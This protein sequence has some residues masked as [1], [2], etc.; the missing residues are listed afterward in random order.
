M[1]DDDDFDQDDD[2]ISASESVW[3]NEESGTMV[4]WQILLCVP[5]VMI[6]ATTAFIAFIAFIALHDRIQMKLNIA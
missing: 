6:C 5:P 2:I 3:E 1:H 4:S